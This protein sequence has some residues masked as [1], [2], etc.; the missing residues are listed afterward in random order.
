[1]SADEGVGEGRREEPDGGIGGGG[2]EALIGSESASPPDGLTADVELA[3]LDIG[4]V[5]TIV[6]LGLSKIPWPR[7][8]SNF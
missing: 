5:E 6:M 3:L 2:D 4:A 7:R 1:M 8:A